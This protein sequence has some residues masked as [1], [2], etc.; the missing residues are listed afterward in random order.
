MRLPS[1][2]FFTKG[3]PLSGKALACAPVLV[4]AALFLFFAQSQAAKEKSREDSADLSII[5]TT[6][7]HSH[8]DSRHGAPSWLKLATKIRKEIERSGGRGKTLLLDCGD[9]IQGSLVGTISRGAAGIAMLDALEYDAWVPGNHE[10]DFGAKRLSE[11]ILESKTPTIS[12]NLDCP[13]IRTRPWIMLEKSGKRI[14]L[15]GLSYL[16]KGAYSKTDNF[17]GAEEIISAIMPQIMDA[18]P[19]LIIL[20]MHC[21]M[22]ADKEGPLPNLKRLLLKYPQISIVFG[23]HTHQEVPFEN[24][25]ASNCFIQAGKHAECAALVQV[26]FR[27]DSAPEIKPRLIFPDASEAEDEKCRKTV[28]KWLDEQRKMDESP[29]AKLRAPIRHEPAPAFSPAADLLGKAIIAAGDAELAFIGPLNPDFELR[30]EIRESDLFEFAP[31]EDKICVMRLDISEIRRIAEEQSLCKEENKIQRLC[32]AS[33]K[34]EGY[35]TLPH[36]KNS[37]LVAFSEYAAFGAGGRFPVLREISKS[38][39]RELRR[40]GISVRD[41]AREQ[42]KKKPFSEP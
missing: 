30:G 10:F 28:S 38:K 34:D 19:D 13:G 35:F 4:L 18:H 6:D 26:S 11:L 1:Y 39:I 8:I 17:D 42:I 24:L 22:H 16:G 20:A 12:A 33:E 23:G 21:G 14:A 40:T 9:T 37:Y 36:D 7:I 15:I 32:R 2:S 5:C 27:E 25:G 41:A 31:Y 29:I 3:A